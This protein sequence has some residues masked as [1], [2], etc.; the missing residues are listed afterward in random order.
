MFFHYFGLI[1][2]TVI[3]AVVLA[4]VTVSCCKG[5]WI[6]Y[7]FTKTKLRGFDNKL[8]YYNI[9]LDKPRWE[10]L[11]CTIKKKYHP[12]GN[13]DVTCNK[14]E[15]KQIMV[16]D[17]DELNEYRKKFSNYNKLLNFIKLQE[18]LMK[19]Y[20]TFDEQQRILE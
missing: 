5:H 13:Q 19:D 3:V 14:G 15:S 10:Y 16:N 12:G 2:F 9:H 4:L 6:Y 11:K 17:I 20:N 1:S 7:Q 18:K 8:Q